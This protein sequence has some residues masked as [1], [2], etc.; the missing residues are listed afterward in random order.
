VFLNTA[1]AGATAVKGFRRAAGTLVGIFSG[2]LLALLAAGHTVVIVVLLALCLFGITYTVRVSQLVASFFITSL[3]GLL[4]SLLGTFSF[5]V[6]WLRVLETFIGVAA[7]L[8][9][10]VAVLPVRTRAVLR[11]DL[12]K[13]LE[14]LRALV[15]GTENLLAGRENV[16]VI[17]LSRELDR[18]VEKVR[19]TLEPLTHPINVVSRRYYTAYVLSALNGIAFRAR[20]VAARAEPGLLAGDDRLTALIDRVCGNIAVVADALENGQ[21]RSR[22]DRDPAAPTMHESDDAEVR[23]VLTNLDRL[24]E[25]IIALGRALGAETTEDAGPRR[26]PESPP[27]V[28][29]ISM[30]GPEAPPR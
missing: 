8:L 24:D 17:E 14:N 9:A 26:G 7:G 2:M 6:L 1:S 22:L 30:A 15:R 19:T 16:N 4:Y 3:L 11:A 25:S 27:A 5:D 21:T 28:T 18:A 20:N 12:R 23:T 13:V 29:M 10:A